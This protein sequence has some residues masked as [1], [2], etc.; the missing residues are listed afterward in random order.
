MTQPNYLKLAKQGDVQAIGVLINRSLQPKGINA[1]IAFKNSCLKVMLESTLVPE[2]QV[3][4]EF[5]RRGITGLNISSVKIVQVYG[6]QTGED[7]PA[8]SQEFTLAE[9]LPPSSNSSEIK[10]T[11]SPTKKQS[12]DKSSEYYQS[13]SGKKQYD[14]KVVIFVILSALWN[15]CKWY[16]SGFTGKSYEET[17]VSSKFIRSCHQGL[18][19]F[20][21]IIFIILGVIILALSGYHISS[22]P[23]SSVSSS[24]G[25]G[26]ESSSIPSSVPNEVNKFECTTLANAT[27]ATTSSKPA[28]V[29]AILS[30]KYTDNKLVQLVKEYA[31]ALT[32]EE[33][34]FQDYKTTGFAS[35]REQ[36]QTYYDANKQSLEKLKEIDQ[37]C[38]Q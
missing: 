30:I 34:A 5:I 1:K 17:Y 13:I 18:R 11:N 36:K 24:S 27:N 32:V 31:A 19:M 23:V 10:L 14:P 35:W 22:P 2:Q 16:I 25:S 37:Y 29:D 12:T 33:L 20:V 9:E 6:R 4:V 15:F 21:N 38:N 28:R 26:S 8:W 7:F 3:L